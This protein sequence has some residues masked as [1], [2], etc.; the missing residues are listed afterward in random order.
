MPRE[1]LIPYFED[2][3]LPFDPVGIFSTVCNYPNSFFLDSS[4]DKFHSGQF[5]FMGF[6]P[7]LVY[8]SRNKDIEVREDNKTTFYKGNPF[9]YLQEY[10]KQYSFKTISELPPFQGG[11]V[12]YFGYDLGHFIEKFDILSRE[13]ME[14]PDCYICFYSTIIMFDHRKKKIL[15]CTLTNK[16]DGIN[17]ATKKIKEIKNLIVSSYLAK[18]DLSSDFFPISYNF[19]SNFTKK[20]YLNTII[21]AKEYIAA[22]DIYQVNLSQRFSVSCDIPPFDLYLRLRKINPAPFAAFLN[23]DNVKILSSSPERF[24]RISR[25]HVE[26]RPIKGTRPRS[27]DFLTDK[28]LADELLKSEKDRAELVMIVDLERNDLGKVCRYG[29]V[30]VPKLLVLETHP[31]VYHLVSTIRGVLHKEKDHIACLKACFPGGSITGAPKIRSMEIIEELEPTRRKVYTGSIG[32][33]GFNRETD[34]NIAIRTIILTNGRAYF[35]TGGGI[36]ADSDP[37]AEY[38]ETLFKAR[39]MFSALNNE[40]KVNLETL[41]QIF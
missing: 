8:K 27:S 23:F 3:P 32:Y 18:P 2:L 39:A 37:E 20:K 26:T 21:K 22:G 30:T 31:S 36:V 16:G 35:Q 4:M 25:D 7:F 10:L 33:I 41:P 14:I 29:S 28:K 38:N 34:L 24:L 19:T 17:K 40:K 9:L 1:N 11:A 6:D 15:I 12:G 13:D 5:S